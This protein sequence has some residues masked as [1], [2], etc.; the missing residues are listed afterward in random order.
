[1]DSEE[2]SEIG[3]IFK[4]IADAIAN[5][6]RYSSFI[7]NNVRRDRY[8][9]AIASAALRFPIDDHYDINH[10]RCK[11]PALKSNGKDWLAVRLGKAITQRRKYL[12]YCREHHD[13]TVEVPKP[14]FPTTLDIPSQELG[15]K[16]AVEGRVV[17]SKYPSTLAPTQASTLLLTGNFLLPEDHLNDETYSQTSY[18]TSTEQD[19]GDHKLDVVPLATVSQGL[20]NFE[21]P[22]CW[23]VPN[24]KSQS[25]WR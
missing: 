14:S 16:L 3:E 21:C 13:K 20:T 11:F 2:L 17:Q 8:A 12:W 9:K 4:A 6:F 24:I 15:R 7:R 10:V 5:L 18:A 19:F 25:S 1:M 23:Q 22:Y